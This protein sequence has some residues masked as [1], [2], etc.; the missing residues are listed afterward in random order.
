M[1]VTLILETVPVISWD[2]EGNLTI[3]C[4][5]STPFITMILTIPMDFQYQRTRTR[6]AI[7]HSL[8][9]LTQ[10]IQQLQGLTPTID[11]PLEISRLV[12]SL[13]EATNYYLYVNTENQVVLQCHVNKDTIH[14][15]FPITQN[16][17]FVE[18]LTYL[19][20]QLEKLIP[21]RSPSRCYVS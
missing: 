16:P 11:A 13:T 18:W 1:A 7:Q 6:Q 14:M 20:S 10:I 5:S 8:T 17:R 3:T 12:L 2:A 15:K 4:Q 21:A 19:K 9:A